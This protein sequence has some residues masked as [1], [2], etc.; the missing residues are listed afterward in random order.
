MN[1]F[2]DFPLFLK[3]KKKICLP[4]QE[5]K[6]QDRLDFRFWANSYAVGFAVS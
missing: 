1:F 5:F 3:R 6:N 4:Y 2:P